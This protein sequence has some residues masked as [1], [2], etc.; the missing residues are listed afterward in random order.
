MKPT[1]TRG[2]LTVSPFKRSEEIPEEQQGFQYTIP[3]KLC[4]RFYHQSTYTLGVCVPCV[5]DKVG[6]EFDGIRDPILTLYNYLDGRIRRLERK[7]IARS[8]ELGFERQVSLAIFK[9][10]RKFSARSLKP[11]ESDEAPTQEEERAPQPEAEVR[12]DQPEAL[13]ASADNRV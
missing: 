10:S 2:D 6:P 1:V 3:C 12:N 11:A 9:E 8:Q 4:K 7:L 5:L 13:A